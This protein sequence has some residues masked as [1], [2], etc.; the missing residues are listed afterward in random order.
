MSVTAENKSGVIQ[1]SILADKLP[2]I[3]RHIILAANVRNLYKMKHTHTHAPTD[4]GTHNNTHTQRK[5]CKVY[6]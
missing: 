6:F 2:V 1:Q 5:E 3:K 4:R